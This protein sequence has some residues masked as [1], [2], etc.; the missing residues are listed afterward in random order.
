MSYS[1]DGGQ[2]FAAPIPIEN[3]PDTPIGG[4]G[5]ARRPYIA[6][7]GQRVAV[8]WGTAP[9][10]YSG[11]R[12][13][14]S[15]DP[16]TFGPKVEVG[17]PDTGDVE[18]FQKVM[19]DPDGDVWVSWHWTVPGVS[20]AKVVSREEDG[21]AHEV[22]TDGA[23]GEPC[24]C[25]PHDMRVNQAGDTL[26]AYRNNINN[27]RDHWVVGSPDSGASFG[28]P[29]QGSSTGWEIPACPVSGPRL[30][31]TSGGRQLL[32]WAD[33]TSGESRVWIGYSDDGGATW[34]G[35]ALVRDE[36][37]PQSLPKITTEAGGRILLA[38]DQDNVGHLTGS[39]D[40]GATF[41][42]PVTISSDDGALFRLELCSG[43]TRS[44]LVGVTA[45]G[46]IW[47]AGQ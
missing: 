30:A 47:W 3:G 46:S 12:I 1:S 6:T 11:V 41:L 40:D 23:P 7:D 13:S 25:C 4:W 17:T 26:V 15:L 36:G 19:F 24:D 44:G 22:I 14:T 16:L 43:P 32:T 31:E 37:G 29:V 34:G 5:P 39:L 33:P 35:D 28:T 42:E 27:L 45:A 8:S 2:S 20:E 18:E 10:G 38:Y 9:N 21:W